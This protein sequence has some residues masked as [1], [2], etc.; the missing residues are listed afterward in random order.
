[1]ITNFMHAC[2]KTVAIVIRNSND[3]GSKEF[4]INANPFAHACGTNF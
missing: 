2:A 4:L 3:S 1:M